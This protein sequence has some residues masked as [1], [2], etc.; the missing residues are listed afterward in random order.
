VLHAGIVEPADGP[1]DQIPC[2]RFEPAGQQLRRERLAGRE[3]QGDDLG[4][5]EQARTRVARRHGR[6]RRQARPG[7]MPEQ[8]EF[9]EASRASLAEPEIAIPR[10]PRRQAAAQVAAQHVPALPGIEEQHRPAAARE[11][12]QRAARPPGSGIEELRRVVDAA[13]VV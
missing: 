6:R 12:P 7:E 8:G 11:L 2:G 9:T 4:A 13:G 5:V 3:M 1:T 10:D